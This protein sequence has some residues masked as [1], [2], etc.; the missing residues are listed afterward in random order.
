[1]SASLTGKIYHHINGV[2]TM[3]LL[4]M[5]IN[6]KFI[7]WMSNNYYILKF[8]FP[9]QNILQT[10]YFNVS[11]HFLSYSSFTAISEW[12]KMSVSQLTVFSDFYF[13]SCLNLN[14]SSLTD[15]EGTPL[16]AQACKS[17]HGYLKLTMCRDTS[18]MKNQ[19]FLG[20]DNRLKEIRAHY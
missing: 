19:N 2:A 1:M 20:F 14:R 3:L 7:F 8:Q 11:F 5:V 10:F 9:W 15:I 13:L 18:I 16:P 17:C 4:R 6:I 12:A